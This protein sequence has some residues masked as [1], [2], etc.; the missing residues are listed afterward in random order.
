MKAVKIIDK[1]LTFF[2][3]V[4][5]THFAARIFLGLVLVGSAVIVSL[6][7]LGQKYIPWKNVCRHQAWQ[8]V[9]LLN[10]FNI[11]YVHQVGFKKDQSNKTLGHSWV[12][13]YGF[14]ITGECE[15][16]EYKII[17]MRKNSLIV[18]KFKLI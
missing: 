8:A 17:Q 15:I 18:N 13:S 11:P 1:G 5:L 7:P 6:S 4:S 10:Y 2:A 14:F 16:Q 9:Y 3:A 12:I